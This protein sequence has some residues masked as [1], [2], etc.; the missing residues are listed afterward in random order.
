M[1]GDKCK[2]PLNWDSLWQINSVSTTNACSALCVDSCYSS[3]KPSQDWRSK[4]PLPGSQPLILIVVP[5]KQ[6][7]AC[8]NAAGLCLMEPTR[9][10]Y[11]QE[12]EVK[13][14]GCPK[15]IP[16]TLASLAEVSCRMTIGDL[17]PWSPQTLHRVGFLSCD[18]NTDMPGLLLP[19]NNLRSNGLTNN[20]RNS[21]HNK[22]INIRRELHLGIY[23]PANRSAQKLTT[24]HCLVNFQSK[25]LLSSENP[26]N[27]M[28]KPVTT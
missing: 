12:A 16:K 6:S 10:H 18:T 22:S 9:Q 7:C 17:H 11:V 1:T 26:T 13:S 8:V 14:C 24:R 3:S 4:P 2:L 27:S 25:S 23:W 15:L 19:I 20:F 5:S 28:L 21:L